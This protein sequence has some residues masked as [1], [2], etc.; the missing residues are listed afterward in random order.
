MAFARTAEIPAIKVLADQLRL[1]LRS[2]DSPARMS[3]MV[4]DVPPGGG[5]PPHSHAREE[6]GYFVLQGEL[7]LTVGAETRLLGA[8]DFGH[9]PP[10]TLHAYAN[11]AMDTVRF[12]AWTV[13]GPI[14]EF[15]EAMSKRVTQMPRDAAAMQELTEQ[16]G[17]KM[18]AA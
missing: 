17:V 13:G 5:V 12:L 11:Q 4:V 1:L 9:V 8:G 18:G 14:D 16:Y 10:R 7:A 15:F 6:E 3:V 2:A